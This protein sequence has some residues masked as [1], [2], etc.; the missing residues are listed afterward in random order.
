MNWNRYSSVMEQYAIKTDV[1]A[2]QDDYFMATH[3]PFSNLEVITGGNE[4]G[5][6]KLMTEE[7]VY[8]NLIYNP[9]NIHRMIIVRG[10]NGAGKSH[11]VRWLRARY[12]NDSAKYNPENEKIIFLRRLNNTI[13]GAISQILEENII[14]DTDMIVKLQ[15][16]IASADAQ[17]SDTFKTSIYHAFINLVAND[18]SGK[19]YKPFVCKGIQDFLYDPRART[20]LMRDDGAINRCYKAI[21][22]PSDTV[23]E[24]EA[25]FNE[26]DF[27]LQRTTMRELQKQGSAESKDFAEQLYDNPDE[28]Q[29]FVK[30]LNQFTPKVIQSC[31][32]I[33]SES[34]RDVF[35]QLRKSLKKQGKGLAIFIEDF[36]A[37]TGIDSE[38]ITVLSAEHGGE[39]SDLCR[40]TAII[41][42]T[43][44]YYGQFKDNFTDRVQYQI[45]V[46]EN[47]Y[48]T[49]EFLETMTALYLNAIY[50][51]PKA[52][53]DWFAS[54]ADLKRLP[55]SGF[56]PGYSWD[57]VSI[58][59]TPYTL[60][61]FNKSSLSILYGNLK[62]KTPRKFLTEAIKSQ[63]KEFFDGQQYGNFSFPTG[64]FLADI[65]NN[66]VRMSPV[67]ASYIDTQND[68]T[69]S[70][71]KRLKLVLAIWG[72][73]TAE[74]TESNNE[75]YIGGVAKKFLKEIGLDAAK[76][77]MTGASKP[78]KPTPV[79]Q[80]DPTPSPASVVVPQKQRQ[81]E[82]KK[83]DI[84]AWYSEKSEL[85]YSADYRKWFLE[86]LRSAINWQAEGIPAYIAA[87]RL[88]EQSTVYIDGQSQSTLIDKALIILERNNETQDILH[89]L[90]D[91]DY[92][93]GWIF[94]E[95]AYY[96][97]KLVN[98]LEK[99]K[100]VIKAKVCN[101]DDSANQWPVL[102][103]CIAVEYIVS[104][105]LGRSLDNSSNETLARDL[106]VV[107]DLTPA[108]IHESSKWS[109][110]VQ[111][112]RT[113]SAK[114]TG[115]KTLMVE[116]AKTFMGTIPSNYTSA[117]VL[118]YR[119]LEISKAIE[120]LQVSNWDISDTLPQNTKASIILSPADL[121]KELY[122]RVRSIVLAEIEHAQGIIEKLKHYLGGE[123]SKE[124]I[125]DTLN[126]VSEMYTVFN[127]NNILYNSTTRAKFDIAPIEKAKII[128][129]K[130]ALVVEAASSDNIIKK[131][132]LLSTNPVKELSSL[133]SDFF[134]I[135]RIALTEKSNAD[136]EMKRLTGGIDLTAITSESI[137][138]LSNLADKVE[139]LGVVSNA[140]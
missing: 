13:R 57:Y 132:E 140:N 76:G 41:G 86:F 88:Q 73:K 135:E 64:E 20:H 77:L 52:I 11:L 119:T 35:I 117:K 16:F 82:A 59:N 69:A 130:Y 109:D 1:I 66:L 34:T 7:E 87:S 49:A 38:L 28:I 111:Y 56:K 120:M 40:V 75:T 91:Y 72:N 27:T 30:Y 65:A 126:A 51:E 29:K 54:G 80:P 92:Y 129:N 133:L 33:S 79:P 127:A 83:H 98:W 114:F 139:G 103:W 116:T 63:L 9:E 61:P 24:G 123:V 134:E 131:L 45:N 39:N 89:A 23:F 19:V 101:C 4:S 17:D 124:A 26:E 22:S 68:I 42:I 100:S 5:N 43:D 97:L 25:T 62:S 60:Y 94:K 128:I 67:H 55:A 3:M 105:I 110:V 96:Q 104:N 12:N 106:F 107:H 74:T 6:T 122:P 50:C 58:N 47:T 53:Q 37:F 31:A 36:T 102:Q 99:N 95:A 115:T 46:T 113:N 85:A 8:Q 21:T 10:N 44:A 78:Q 108:T 71:K 137:E 48:N 112:I 14:T 15:R 2:S 118:F 125:I 121:L 81:Y 70:D 93:G 84:T 18:K 90:C 32:E 138:Y 136:N